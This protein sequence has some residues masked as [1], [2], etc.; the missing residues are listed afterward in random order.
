MNDA[1][2]IGLDVHQATFSVAVR[3]AAGKLVMEAVVETKAEAILRFLRGVRGS[4]QVTLGKDLGRWRRLLRQIPSIGPIRAATSSFL[5]NR[6]SGV[7]CG[8]SRSCS[9]AAQ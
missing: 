6:Q 3:D 5:P 2:Y 4:L 1:K 7:T 9:Q 8:R